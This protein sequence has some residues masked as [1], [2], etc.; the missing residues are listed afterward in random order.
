MSPASSSTTSPGTTWAEGRATVSPPRSTLAV[1]A[2]MAFRLSRLF[3]ALRY[4]TVPSTALSSSTA[5][6]TRVLSLWPLAREMRAAATRM[7]TSRSLNCSANTC[8]AL[9]FLPSVSLFSPCFSSRRAASSADKPCA[10]TESSSRVC[11]AVFSYQFFIF[12]ASRGFLWAREM[13]G[14]L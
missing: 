5:K 14:R 11:C 7:M 4:C 9:F 12:S 3:S 10:E 13:P 1:G 6:M 2:D 8:K